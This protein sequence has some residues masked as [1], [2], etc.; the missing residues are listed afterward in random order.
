[1]AHDVVRILD[2]HHAHDVLVLNVSKHTTIA[3]YFIIATATSR[4]QMEALVDALKEELAGDIHHR[5]GTPRSDWIL[6]DM[7]DIVVH[8]FLPEARDFYNL[9]RLWADFDDASL[10]DGQSG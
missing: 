5:E 10:D 3:D 7:R 1:L 9:E 4:A 8:L 2:A 6:V